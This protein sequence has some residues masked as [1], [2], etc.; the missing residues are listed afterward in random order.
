M[1][2]IKVIEV[3]GPGCPR[4]KATFEVV[5]QVVATAGIACEV[6]KSESIDR[7]VELGLLATPG[8]AVDGTVVLSGRVPG[9]DEVRRAL[10]L[11]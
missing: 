5:R 4:C 1:G 10:G 3:L 6:I 9:P 7:M 11:A 8:V 2:E